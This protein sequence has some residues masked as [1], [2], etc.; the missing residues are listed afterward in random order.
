MGSVFDVAGIE[1]GSQIQAKNSIVVVLEL[2][3]CGLMLQVN[4]QIWVVVVALIFLFTWEF[5]IFTFYERGQTV[6]PGSSSL[7]CQDPS[8]GREVVRNNCQ[9]NVWIMSAY[10]SRLKLGLSMQPAVM[11]QTWPGSSESLKNSCVLDPSATGYA[12]VPAHA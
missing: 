6:S 1:N 12:A 4:T 7:V 3:S 10:S 2:E 9:E 8:V 11:P 5:F